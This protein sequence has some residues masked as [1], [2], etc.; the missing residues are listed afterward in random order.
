MLIK[1]FVITG[2]EECPDLINDNF[3]TQTQTRAFSVAQSNMQ[4]EAF[5]EQ[6]PEISQVIIQI[7]DCT[8]LSYSEMVQILK[9]SEDTIKCLVYHGEKVL[10][11]FLTYESG[12][13]RAIKQPKGQKENIPVFAEMAVRIERLPKPYR[14]ILRLHYLEGQSY[15]EM[16]KL[17]GKPKGTVKSLVNR[18]KKILLEG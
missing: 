2:Q 6:L 4:I 5:I 14:T 18:G 8:N 11:W 3:D 13:Q 17:L 10:Q 7:H 9:E 12:M 15:S 16:A 1:A